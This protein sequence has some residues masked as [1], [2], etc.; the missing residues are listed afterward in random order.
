M[1]NLIFAYGSLI[2][3]C[4]AATT[5]LKEPNEIVMHEAYLCG[6]KRIWNV[7]EIAFSPHGERIEVVYLNIQK[8]LHAKTW[9][10]ILEC[11]YDELC[12]L[13]KRE[14]HYDLVNVTDHIQP[15]QPQVVSTFIGKPEHVSPTNSAVI[16]FDY[17]MTLESGLKEWGKH[18]SE[19]FNVTTQPFSYSIC[20]EHL[21]PNSK[22]CK[23]NIAHTD[24]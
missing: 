3:R 2:N 21:I 19:N 16:P 8:D 4:S 14:R 7:S 22:F 5:L 23:K 10:V 9:G 15:I 17:I 1:R 6:Y 12:L 11:T 13:S 18:A 20:K 24:R